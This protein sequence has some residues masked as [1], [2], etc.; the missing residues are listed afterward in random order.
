MTHRVALLIS[1]EAENYIDF[2]RRFR[3]H[4]F[5]L[6]F[7]TPVATSRPMESCG[8]GYK[9]GFLALGIERKKRAD[10]RRISSSTKSGLVHLG[11]PFSASLQSRAKYF[12]R[13]FVFAIILLTA[14]T[15]RLTS[16]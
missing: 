5:T 13:D 7:V 2:A 10:A 12:A 1:V 8:M 14:V 11:P 3:C 9:T 4:S 15:I 16:R 6:A